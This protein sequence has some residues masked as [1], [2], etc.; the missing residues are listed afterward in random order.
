MDQCDRFVQNLGSLGYF[1]H[2]KVV[3]KFENPLMQSKPFN[4]KI[5]PTT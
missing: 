3:T 2:R 4:I 1:Y 5:K